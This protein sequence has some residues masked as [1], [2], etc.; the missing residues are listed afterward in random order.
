PDGFL[1][2]PLPTGL[3]YATVIGRPAYFTPLFSPAVLLGLWA[4]W[5]RRAWRPAILLVGWP[6]VVYLFLAGIAWQSLRFTLQMLPPLAILVALGLDDLQQSL[7]GRAQTLVRAWGV[8][9]L[10][11]MLVGAGRNIAMFTRQMNA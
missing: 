11:L 9:G 7:R 6:A 10:V 2:Y 5:R 4:L 3:F 1:S 8:A